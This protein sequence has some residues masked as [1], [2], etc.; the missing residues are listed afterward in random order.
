MVS[1]YFV[2]SAERVMF[3]HGTAETASGRL[4]GSA[5]FGHVNTSPFFTL[6]STP[7][8]MN[9]PNLSP[10]DSNRMAVG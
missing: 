4:T 2:N 10:S 8:Y 7:L 6:P 3:I 1:A 9:Y 5:R